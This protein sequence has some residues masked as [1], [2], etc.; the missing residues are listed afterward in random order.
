[1]KKPIIQLIRILKNAELPV[2]SA[3]LADELNLSPRSVKSYIGEINESFPGTIRSSRKGYSILPDKA[4]AILNAEESTIPQTSN[5]RIS[6]ILNMLIRKGPMNAYTLS[7]EMFISYSTLKSELPKVRRMLSKNDLELIVQADTLLINGLEKNKR[8]LLSS[9]LYNESRNNFVDYDRM[10]AAFRQIDVPYIK[11]TILDEFKRNHYFI[12][13]YSL[14]NL[15]LHVTIAI[16][17]IRNGYTST[18]E[19]L[20]ASPIR[21]HEHELAT[22]IIHK[23]ERHFQVLFNDS[24]TTEFTLLIL[25]RASNLDYKTITVENIRGYIGEDV[26]KLTEIIITDLS[27]YFY[28]D[29]SQ[30]EFFIRFALHLKNVLVR[31][32][33]HYFS[34]NPLTGSIKQKC[35]LIYDAAVNAART[36]H[37]Y[38][39]IH[40][41]DDEI[42][43]IAFHIGGALEIQNSIRSKLSAAL[44]CPNYYNLN[45]QLSEKIT[46]RFRDSLMLTN[47]LTDE[48]E[49]GKTVADL[50]ISTMET[51]RAGT[52]P[53]VVVSPF[54]NDADIH[55]VA[56]KIDFIR[57][58]KKRNL[59]KEL[60]S[61]L[62]KPELFLHKSSMPSKRAVIHELCDN[63]YR[64][65]YTR[66][67]FEEQVMERDAMSSTAFGLFAIP[68]AM[69]MDEY[70]TAVSVMILDEPVHWDADDVQLVML[71]CFNRNERYI[72]NEVFEPIT[73][74][75]TNPASVRRL[76]HAGSGMEFIEA[77]TAAI[78]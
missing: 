53:L 60:L 24:E 12:N 62:L 68:H 69:K 43:Y 37:E 56:D 7:D 42:A 35:P 4:A 36:I 39:G 45:S 16:D 65:G 13:D 11:R 20:P 77:I 33:S 14:E 58:Q 15:V 67:S 5:E 48:E 21:M 19:N 61:D 8:K 52:V 78:G 44:F 40:L 17:R 27:A 72:F 22:A 30:P 3:R 28:I 25:S 10:A 38:T 34:K 41:N 23:L 66:A 64:L 59:F 9:L 71:L 54:L 55:N 57:L 51:D 63:L 76:L 75:L 6:Y 1:M 26:Y 46:S 18:K 70:K 29:L 73:M 47:I 32:D 2:T 31:A 74:L 50:L 49:L